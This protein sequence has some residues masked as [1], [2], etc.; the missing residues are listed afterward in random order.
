MEISM[1]KRIYAARLYVS[2]EF[3]P[4]DFLDCETEEELKEAI[5]DHMYGEVDY[6]DIRV[7]ESETNLENINEFV[8]AWKKLKENVQ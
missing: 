5:L 6:G 7:D 4:E 2:F 3:N 1:S 8:E